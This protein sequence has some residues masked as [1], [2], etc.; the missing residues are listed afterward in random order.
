LPR[1]LRE[2][3]DAFYASLGRYTLEDLR[4]RPWR[5]KDGSVDQRRAVHWLRPR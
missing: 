5:I 4:I 2:A 1:A 3:V